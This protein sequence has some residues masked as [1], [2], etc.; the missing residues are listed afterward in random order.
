[1]IV[2][3]A[4]G[5]QRFVLPKP[6]YLLQRI[7]PHFPWL[8]SFA[9]LTTGALMAFEIGMNVYDKNKKTNVMASKVV[10]VM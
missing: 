10:M 6:V 5:R 2:L 9:V 3:I 4:Q 8:I 1:M 7:L